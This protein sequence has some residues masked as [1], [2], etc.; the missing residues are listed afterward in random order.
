MHRNDFHVFLHGS[1]I[2]NNVKFEI[3]SHVCIA[4][5]IYLHNFVQKFEI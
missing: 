1:W 4:M 5:S 2:L 3:F